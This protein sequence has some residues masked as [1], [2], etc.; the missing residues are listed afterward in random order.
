MRGLTE[1]DRAFDPDTI[2]I[3]SGA[4]EDA[5]RVIQANKAQ[6]RIQPDDAAARHVLAKHMLEMAHDGELDRERLMQGA[7]IHLKR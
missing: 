4:L 1:Y 7:L 3:L 6:F 2:L 5:W